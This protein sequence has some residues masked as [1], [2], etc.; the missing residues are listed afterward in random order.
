MSFK[1][2][3]KVTDAQF[4]DNGEMVLALCEKNLYI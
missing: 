1:F 4:L 3:S 2:Q